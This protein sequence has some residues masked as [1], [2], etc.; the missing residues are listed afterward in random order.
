[1]LLRLCLLLTV[2]T[3]SVR[4]A[5]EPTKYTLG[6]DSQRKEGV[7]QGKVEKFTFSTSKVFEGTTRD[8]WVYVP[9]STTPRSRRQ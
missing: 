8:Y 9:C 6:P 1:M 2:L 3:G 7:P 5:D 4:A